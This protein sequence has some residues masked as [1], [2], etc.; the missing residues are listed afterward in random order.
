MLNHDEI[1]FRILSL[2]YEKYWK[3]LGESYVNTNDLIND[4]K[5]TVERNEIYRN[6]LYLHKKNLISGTKVTGS[7]PLP[8][9]K[10]NENGI[11]FVEKVIQDS[12]KFSYDNTLTKELQKITNESNESKIKGFLELTRAYTPLMVNVLS[13]VRTFLYT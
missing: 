2:L 6:I 10:I 4:L 9:I 3:D 1:R 11:E 8:G 12:S 7:E 13:I 5:I